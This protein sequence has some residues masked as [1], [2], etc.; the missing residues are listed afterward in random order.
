MDDNYKNWQ[1]LALQIIIEVIE[2]YK[3]TRDRYRKEALLRWFDTGYGGTVCE[4]AGMDPDYIK[5]E[6]Q[7][8]EKYNRYDNE[9]TKEVYPTAGKES[10][11]QIKGYNLQKE[12]NKEGD[13]QSD[14]GRDRLLEAFRYYQQAGSCCDWVPFSTKIRVTKESEGAGIF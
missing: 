8:I 11:Y 14:A 9:G 6:V 13:Q 4:L 2:D 5:R 10:K 12:P 3:V 1:R 7:N